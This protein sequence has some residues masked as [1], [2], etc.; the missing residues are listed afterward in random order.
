MR[1]PV[2]L[3][4]DEGMEHR[5]PDLSTAGEKTIARLVLYYSVI[6]TGVNGHLIPR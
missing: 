2:L 4:Q 5:Q 1:A 6:K 3:N